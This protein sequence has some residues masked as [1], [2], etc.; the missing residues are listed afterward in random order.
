MTT[1]RLSR[2]EAESVNALSALRAVRMGR[3][4][5]TTITD[6]DKSIQ[7]C[8]F[9]IKAAIS[10]GFIFQMSASVSC[11]AFCGLLPF[12]IAAGTVGR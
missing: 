6:T 11:G 10:S 3:L 9:G 4:C 5:D 2:L 7:K 1:L 12:G 8:Y